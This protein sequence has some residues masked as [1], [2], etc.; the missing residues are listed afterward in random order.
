MLQRYFPFIVIII[1]F[2]KCASVSEDAQS[3]INKSIKAHGGALYENSITEF[4][5]RGRHYVLERDQGN[6]K[7]HR[8]FD[9]SAGNY[10]DIFTNDGFE[11]MLNDQEVKLTNECGRI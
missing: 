2:T 11:R 8:I 6:F 4:D 10:H 3:I 5:F 7:Y 1:I 9:D